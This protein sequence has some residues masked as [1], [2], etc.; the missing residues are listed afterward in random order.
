[1]SM[2]RSPI[3]YFGQKANLPAQIDHALC[4]CLAL[5]R[6]GKVR[7]DEKLDS[8]FLSTPCETEL[9]LFQITVAPESNIGPNMQES[10]QRCQ[11]A[12]KGYFF[13]SS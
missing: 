2:I 13:V 3:I 6:G 8:C 1:M 5:W 9:W 4:L 7:R 11:L 12:E 10:L